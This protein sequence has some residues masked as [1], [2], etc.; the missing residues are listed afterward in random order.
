MTSDSPLISLRGIRFAYGREHTVFDALDFDLHEGERVGLTGSNGSGKSTLLQMI[1]GLLKP[2]AGEITA[3]GKLRR[4]ERDF[5][6]VRM[7]AG[8]LFQDPEDQLFCPTVAD[9]VAFGP[10]NQGK[11]LAEVRN[12]VAETLAEL[13]LQG[14]ERRITCRLS[15]GEK[16]LVSLA[17]VLAMKP[18]VLLLD[19]PFNDLDEESTE[20]LILV[21]SRLPQA[22][23]LVSHQR[24][25]LNCLT[26]KTLHMRNGV[27]L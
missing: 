22:M 17:T 2:S 5:L 14:Y 21:L 12:I 25:F 6:E 7:R 20:R 26:T 27:L 16:R 4:A 3:F 19:E 13:S 23:V 18:D 9:D 1:V 11:P 8:L 24:Q 10:L 15:G